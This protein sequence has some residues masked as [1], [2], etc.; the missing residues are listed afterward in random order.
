VGAKKLQGRI[1]NKLLQKGK[2]KEREKQERAIKENNQPK[3]NKAP[4]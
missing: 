2:T 4:R 1:K 3:K